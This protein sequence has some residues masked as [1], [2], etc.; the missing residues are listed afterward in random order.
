M[1]FICNFEIFVGFDFVC[2]FMAC[3]PQSA[4]SIFIRIVNEYLFK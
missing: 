2:I 4:K 1:N 3:D